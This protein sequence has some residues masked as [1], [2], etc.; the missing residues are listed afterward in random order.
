MELHSESTPILPDGVN[1]NPLISY[2]SSVILSLLL[3]N[4]PRCW[5]PQ[6]QP[7]PWHHWIRYRK[8][9][10]DDTG[11]NK[12]AL[13]KNCLI[14]T[15]FSPKPSPGWGPQNGTY[16]W[17]AWRVAYKMINLFSFS[18]ITEYTTCEKKYMLFT[19]HVFLN[20]QMLASPPE[21]F[22]EKMGPAYER[23]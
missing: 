17:E 21:V 14:V 5:N 12:V 7:G 6:L 10:K 13:G 19:M 18:H 9:S 1:H 22:R 3:G 4:Y 23:E 20:D 11:K 2:K 16:Q 15:A 8:E